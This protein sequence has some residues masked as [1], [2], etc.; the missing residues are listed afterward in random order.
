MSRVSRASLAVVVAGVAGGALVAVPTAG[1]AAPDLAPVMV[2]LDASGSMTAGTAGGGSKM[3]AAKVAV[4]TLVQ[5]APEGARIGLAVYG[6]GTGNS[7]AEKAAGCK[8]VTVVQ[9]VGPLDRPALTARVDGVQPRGYT[10]IGQSLRVAAAELPDSGPRS[11]VLVSDGVDTCA[12]PDPCEVARELAASG[13]ELRVHAIGFDVDGTARQQLTCLAQATGG[14][15]LD[16]PD[17]A[18]LASALNR[19][20]Q[21]ALRFYQPV[22]TPVRG[23]TTPE[24]APRLATGN[25]LDRIGSG[26]KRYYA[27]DVPPGYTLHASATVVVPSGNDFFVTVYR[28]DTRQCLGGAGSTAT[29]TKLPVISTGL[30]W[31]AP[32][33]TG[34]AS[35]S[36]TPCYRP[37]PQYVEVFLDPVFDGRPDPGDGALEVLIGLEPP[38]TGAPG[39]E[40]TTDH[41]RYQAPAGPSKPV[42]GGG[43]FTAAATLDGPGSYTDTVFEGEMVFYRI[44]LDWGQGLAYRLRLG[45]YRYTGSGGGFIVSG[46][47]FDPVRSEVDLNFDISRGEEVT[48][49][50]EGSPTDAI[51]GPPVRYRNRELGGFGS[52]VCIAGWYYL[53]VVAQNDV[54]EELTPVPVTLDVSVNGNAQPAPGYVGGDKDPFGD[55]K[56]GARRDPAGHQRGL[57]STVANI[58]PLLWGGLAL[59]LLLAAVTGILLIRR[60]RTTPAPSRSSGLR[61]P[62]PGAQ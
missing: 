15:Y 25:Y 24:G 40:G 52:G 36:P 23:T 7:A 2:V 16:A 51:G 26:Q 10:P 53:A 61:R 14:T 28:Y 37:G 22:G 20:T 59:L 27:V 50:G 4:R 58:S 5:Q 62:W 54:S 39:P 46:Y 47:F 8:D 9:K 49:P 29:Q 17:A 13:V 56:P 38:L 21:Q 6:T 43:S 42:V 18:T 35:P 3:A 33:A 41:V 32:P 19:V 45:Q 11:I 57:W 31:P 34:A 12:P 55:Q 48:V 60:R 44:R 30:R 1:Y